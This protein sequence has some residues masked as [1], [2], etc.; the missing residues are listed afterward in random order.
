MYGLALALL[1]LDCLALKVNDVVLESHCVL[2]LYSQPS[3]AL[4]SIMAS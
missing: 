2:R 4:K 3:I 1:D